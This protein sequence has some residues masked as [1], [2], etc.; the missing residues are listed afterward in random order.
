MVAVAL[1]AG[2]GADTDACNVGACNASDASADTGAGTAMAT[3]S[4]GDGMGD[5]LVDDALGC[6][7]IGAKGAI[8]SAEGREATKDAAV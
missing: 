6:S 5:T 8:V 7:A 1:E 2:S 4:D 3:V